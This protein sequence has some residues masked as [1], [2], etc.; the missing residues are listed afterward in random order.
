M[1]AGGT[2]TAL[3]RARAD[4]GRY[5]FSSLGR[6]QNAI[7]PARAR[8]A[9]AGHGALHIER[10]VHHDLLPR[11]WDLRENLSAYDAAYVALAEVLQAPLVTS[12]AGL[13]AL[14]TQ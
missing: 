5:A 1:T 14:L 6:G 8:E 7:T 13:R 3:R 10:T 4:S 9:L 12:A 11:I 2:P